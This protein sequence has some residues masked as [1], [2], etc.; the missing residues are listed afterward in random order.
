M[1]NGYEP[2]ILKF[3]KK[4]DQVDGILCVNIDHSRTNEFGAIIRHFSFIDR[5]RFS[6]ALQMG[7]DYIWKN[8]YADTVRVNLFHFKD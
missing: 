7:L 1:K 6:E 5:S 8:L 2:H 3:S 4:R